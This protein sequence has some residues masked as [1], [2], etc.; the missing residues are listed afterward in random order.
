VGYKV[1][2]I[3]KWTLS[4]ARA[5][6]GHNC[7]FYSRNVNKDEEEGWWMVHTVWR[8]NGKGKTKIFRNFSDGLAEKDAN[9]LVLEIEENISRG[10]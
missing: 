8:I 9:L 5:P 4:Q 3:E 2:D 7:I 1:V 10:F 6:E